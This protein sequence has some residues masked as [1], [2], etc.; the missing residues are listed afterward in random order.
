[1]SLD[2][3]SALIEQLKPLLMEPNFQAFFE[4]LTASE[5]NSTRFLLKMELNRLSSPCTRIIDLRDKSELPCKELLFGQQRHFLDEPAR[6]VFNQAIALYRDKYTLGAYEQVVESHKQRKL[7]LREPTPTSTSTSN[8]QDAQ[9]FI[10]PGVVLGSYFNRSEERMNYSIRIS[11]HQQ[12]LGEVSGS[13]IDLSVNGARIR[14]PARHPFSTDKPLVV[15]LLELGDE[16]YFE[17]LQKGVEYQI[18]DIQTT[19]DTCVL[20]LKRVGGSEALSEML[21]KLIQGYKFRYKVDVNDVVTSATGLGFERHYLPHLPHLPLFIE[22]KNDTY[23]ANH[24]LLSRDNQKLHHYFVDE[25]DVNQLPNMLTPNRLNLAISQANNPDHCLFFCFTHSAKEVTYYYSATL[26]EL[27]QDKT[28]SLFLGFGASK[29]SWQ[30]FKLHYDKIDHSKSYKSSVL[31]GDEDH[32]SPLTEQQLSLFSHVIQLMNLTSEHASIDYQSWFDN[33]NA[34]A[35][36]PYGQEKVKNNSIKLI[37]MH[38]SERRQEARYAFKTQVGLTQGTITL[39]SISHDISSRGLQLTLDSPHELDTNKSVMLSLPKL[40]GVAGKAVLAQL[41][42]RI[43]KSRRSGK[44]LHLSA[45]MGHTP[46]TGV[47]FLNKLIVHNKDKLELLTENNNDVKELADGLKNLLMRKLHSTPIFIEKTTKT[48]QM[49]CIGVSTIADKITHIF[50]ADASSSLQY[51][52]TPLL[53][54]GVF[55]EQLVDPIKQMQVQQDMTFFE[56]FIQ[57]SI[58]SRGKFYLKC[59]L[60]DTLANRDMKIKFIQQSKNLGKF[61]ALRI[62]RGVVGKPDLNYIRREREYINIHAPHKAKQLDE[63]LWRIIGV[64]ELIDITQEVELRY[65]ELTR[66]SQSTL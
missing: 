40:Q 52:L 18:V 46:H 51:N 21:R 30:I 12:G 53:E 2:E 1:M 28:L 50:A 8:D 26:A 35:L 16:F 23:I 6:K 56:V 48:I 32:Y 59:A 54:N 5:S 4:Q 37:S 7:A 31:P 29:P 27:K 42:Y 57:L 41:P 39:N 33:S 9:P 11:T 19:A 24:A 66:D 34:N 62:Y 64:G 65:P 55:K 43:V 20:R 44:I 36:K 38:F 15:K 61:I 14:L 47:E 22:H 3:H 45:I 63:Q 58:Q 25:N 60:A 17:D 49:A 10:V 13:T